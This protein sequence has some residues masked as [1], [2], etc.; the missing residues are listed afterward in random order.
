MVVVAAEKA[1]IEPARCRTG[2][3]LVIFLTEVF[4]RVA[5]IRLLTEEEMKNIYGLVKFVECWLRF[6]APG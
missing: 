4:I 6:P 5:K 1:E 2:G 3:K